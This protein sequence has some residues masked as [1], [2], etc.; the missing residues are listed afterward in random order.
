MDDPQKVT[1]TPISWGPAVE[2]WLHLIDE[3]D[4][5]IENLAHCIAE[6]AFQALEIAVDGEP[7][8]VLVWSVENE[9][10]GAVVV[11]NALAVLPVAG[12]D[13]SKLALAFVT[14][15]GRGVGAIAVRFWTKRRGLVRKMERAGFRKSYVMEGA[16]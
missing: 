9:A 6:G 16:L 14:K 3:I 12:L 15:C 1:F 11:V 2:G 8:G 4:A 7:C 13:M 10:R 5:H